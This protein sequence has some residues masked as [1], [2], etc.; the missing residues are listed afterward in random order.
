MCSVLAVY[1]ARRFTLIALS[2][3]FVS[4][5]QE[6]LGHRR[7]DD[8]CPLLSFRPCFGMVQC[9]CYLVNAGAMDSLQRQWARSARDT[10]HL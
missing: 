1:Q 5:C 2:K 6:M 3:P 8:A 10:Q 9:G 7:R 4:F